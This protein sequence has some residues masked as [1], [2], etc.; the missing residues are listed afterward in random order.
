MFRGCVGG[1]SCFYNSSSTGTKDDNDDDGRVDKDKK[2]DILY[3]FSSIISTQEHIYN[4][5]KVREGK[6]LKV[7]LRFIHFHSL[8][9]FY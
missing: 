8:P 5:E 6:K 4:R 3:D 7:D 2:V 9:S 1:P